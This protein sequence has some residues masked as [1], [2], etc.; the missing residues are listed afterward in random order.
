M[1]HF[2]LSILLAFAV[3]GCQSADTSQEAD[4]I[5]KLMKEQEKCWNNGDLECFMAS[6]WK[7][8]KLVFIGKSGPKYGWQTTL[9]NYKKSYPDKR[10]MGQL[11]FEILSTE[12][13]SANAAFVIGKWNLDRADGNL[14]GHYT[15]LWKKIAGKWVIVADHSS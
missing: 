12:I 1:K 8:D 2:L 15:L 6:Y 13:I 4:K 14:N 10:A 9:D 3:A 7:S 11:T 5:L